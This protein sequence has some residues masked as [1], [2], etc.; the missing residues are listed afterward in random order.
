MS[1]QPTGFHHCEI[2]FGGTAKGREVRPAQKRTMSRSSHEQVQAKGIS[3]RKWITQGGSL[4][5]TM[6][7]CWMG[8]DYNSIRLIKRWTIMYSPS[9]PTPH[10][11]SLDLPP[12]LKTVGTWVE[13]YKA[14][15]NVLW[16]FLLLW[17]SIQVC[18]IVSLKRLTSWRDH[19]D[20][21]FPIT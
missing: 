6:M 14:V 2:F 8:F 3:Q 4:W 1:R 19:C 20:S 5:Y 16:C 10:I 9:I 13:L 17:G 15:P 18:P 12:W 7:Q 11:S 21:M